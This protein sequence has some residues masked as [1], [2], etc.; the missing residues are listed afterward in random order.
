MFSS[1]PYKRS[2]RVSD[3]IRKE[4]AYIFSFEISDPRLKNL[5]V[6]QVS[7]SDDL[8]SAK[9]FLSN[10]LNLKINKDTQEIELALEKSKSFVKKKLG[11]NIKLKKIPEL[12][13][14]LEEEDS[15]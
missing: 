3:S 4:I 12:L 1:K 8:S 5:T 13:F 11:K 15:I 6:T 14:F 2:Q 7:L 10:Y 9:V